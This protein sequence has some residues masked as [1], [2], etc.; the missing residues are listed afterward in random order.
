MSGVNSKVM[1]HMEKKMELNNKM[2][3]A[4]TKKDGSSGWK[5]YKY[6]LKQGDDVITREIWGPASM[7]EMMPA[8]K[9][10]SDGT[11][12]RGGL[13]NV[14]KEGA[15]QLTKDKHLLSM[16]LKKVNLTML[17]QGLENAVIKE[18]ALQNL[19]A[20]GEPGKDRSFY[21]ALFKSAKET[22]GKTLQEAIDAL[23]IDIRKYESQDPSRDPNPMKLDF[24]SRK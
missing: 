17:Q 14:G 6:H 10:F 4:L 9:Q 11:Y 12:V 20:Q 23:T 16:R 2:L 21:L 18:Q 22:Q 24:T 1:Q 7:S 8:T 5:A 19:V 15:S 13:A 3:A